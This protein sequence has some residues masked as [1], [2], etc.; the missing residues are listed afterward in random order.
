[1]LNKKLT[2]LSCTFT[3]HEGNSIDSIRGGDRDKRDENGVKGG[4]W[5]ERYKKKSIW[6][7]SYGKDYV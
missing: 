3:E 2:N 7:G 1:M 4:D 5:D 6:F